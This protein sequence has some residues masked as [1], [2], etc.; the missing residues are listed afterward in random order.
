VTDD[1]IPALEA[2]LTSAG[3]AHSVFERDELGGVYD[4]D[5]PAWYARWAVD[6]GFGAAFGREVPSEDLAKYF[7]DTWE[8]IRSADPKA[9]EP[10]AT[11][12][13]RRIVSEL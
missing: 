2:L 6:H 12:M 1:H 8:E 13:A 3:E 9:T 10:W 5:W 7:T 4:E 11:I